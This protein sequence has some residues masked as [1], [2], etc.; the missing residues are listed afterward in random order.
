MSERKP[1]SSSSLWLTGVLLMVCGVLAL[2]G[3][4]FAGEAVIT[5]I[6]V[7]LLLAGG[8]QIIGVFR[9]EKGRGEWAALVQGIIKA[10]AGVG[11]LAH[12]LL[13]L[14]FLTLLLTVFFVAEG[15]WKAYSS[16]AYRPASGW[17]AVLGS[18]VLSVLL[19]VMLWYDWPVSGLWAVGIL[20]GVDLLATG[21]AL[22][23][24]ATTLHER[25]A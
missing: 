15:L 6:G 7:L 8:V 25:K 17:L 1:P 23:A 20:V 3:P 13:G 16:F 2:A 5:V 9:A 21:V 24:V 19:G 18:G 12:P 14:S 22:V 4:A 10:A 11:V